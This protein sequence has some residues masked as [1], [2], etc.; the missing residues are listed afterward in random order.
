MNWALK[1]DR[2]DRFVIDEVQTEVR[3]GSRLVRRNLDGERH[4]DENRKDASGKSDERP[5]GHKPMF[6]VR[7]R[8]R[9]IRL[10]G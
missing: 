2:R 7:R 5:V 4:Q 9:E 1:T 8:R 3:H 10:E 6:L